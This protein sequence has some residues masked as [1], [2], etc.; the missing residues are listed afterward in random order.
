VAPQTAVFRSDADRRG[1]ASVFAGPSLAMVIP[2]LRR[3]G[4]AATSAYAF[5]GPGKPLCQEAIRAGVPRGEAADRM[6]FENRIHTGTPSY[7]GYPVE[8]IEAFQRRSVLSIYDRLTYDESD[9]ASTR[10][11]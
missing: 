11:Y 10:R 8:L 1:L 3:H 4:P 2:G 5:E 6:R 9:L 7:V